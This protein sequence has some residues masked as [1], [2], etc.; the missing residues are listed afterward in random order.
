MTKMWPWRKLR[1][2][3]LWLSHMFS[4]KFKNLN[5]M[6]KSKF[7]V[8]LLALQDICEIFAGC[9][10]SHRYLNP[11]SLHPTSLIIVITIITITITTLIILTM[12][13]SI[14]R[15]SNYV[16]CLQRMKPDLESELVGSNQPLAKANVFFP[17]KVNLIF[18]DGVNEN[19]WFKLTFGKC[20][21]LL[22]RW[23]MLGN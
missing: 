22:S 3:S 14:I 15:C 11:V 2:F 23:V 19:D 17:D 5:E 10:R 7:T 6:W 12:I 16:W 8:Q 18:I 20:Q 4:K 9:L 1:C 21:C 13:M